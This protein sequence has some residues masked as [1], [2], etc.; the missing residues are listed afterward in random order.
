MV[1]FPVQTPIKL[2]VKPITTA[3]VLANMPATFERLH[4]IFLGHLRCED[5]REY[6]RLRRRLDQIWHSQAVQNFHN[7]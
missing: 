7:K 6:K 5:G 3:N 1:L 2:P 4:Q